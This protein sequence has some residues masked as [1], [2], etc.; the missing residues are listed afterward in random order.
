M[1]MMR[2]ITSTQIPMNGHSGASF[3][4]ADRHYFS[5]KRTTAGFPEVIKTTL[6]KTK[7][8]EHKAYDMS[9]GTWRRVTV[10]RNQDHLT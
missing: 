8:L 4:A 7:D 6:P 10:R 9:R 1:M 5:N 3:P 2:T